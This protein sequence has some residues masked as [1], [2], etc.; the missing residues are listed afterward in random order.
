MTWVYAYSI[1]DSD[2]KERE[3]EIKY[4]F[5]FINTTIAQYPVTTREMLANVAALEAIM[6]SA[7]SHQIEK[8]AIE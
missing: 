6:K 1:R 7:E 4:Y 3:K 2:K 5:D 8:I